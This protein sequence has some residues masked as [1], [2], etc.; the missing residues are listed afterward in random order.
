MF[1]GY[2]FP[3]SPKLWLKLIAVLAVIAGVD[4]TLIFAPAFA[5]IPR[6]S[7]KPPAQGGARI[8]DD[9]QGNQQPCPLSTLVVSVEKA[10]SQQPNAEPVGAE[11]KQNKVAVVSLP[12]VSVSSDYR[13]WIKRLYDWGPWGFGG[14]VAIFSGLQIRL[15]RL[16]LKRVS[17]QADVANRQAIVMVKQLK[18]MESTREVETRTLILQYRP[19]IL[20]RGAAVS[21]LNLLRCQPADAGNSPLHCSKHRGNGRSHHWRIREDVLR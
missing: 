1:L 20:V 13:G 9:C 3:M 18:E 15:L 12:P 17:R 6:Q 8:Q 11:N 7:A 5:P 16:T 4:A 21:D 19:K 10:G 2:N 14:L